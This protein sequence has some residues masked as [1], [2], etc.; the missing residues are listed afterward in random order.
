M[1]CVQNVL[2]DFWIF[3]NAK[4][5]LLSRSGLNLFS[6][7]LS[8]KELLSGALIGQERVKNKRGSKGLGIGPF[9][10]IRN[11]PALYSKRNVFLVVGPEYAA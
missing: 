1:R 2:R 11:I 10:T 5:P 6:K 8:V 7:L 9:H 3:L 4:R